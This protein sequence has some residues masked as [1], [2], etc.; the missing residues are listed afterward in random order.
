MG[1]LAACC[2]DQDAYYLESIPETFASPACSADVLLYMTVDLT[3]AG[4]R[5]VKQI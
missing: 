3:C 1:L 4:G 5:T 2:R